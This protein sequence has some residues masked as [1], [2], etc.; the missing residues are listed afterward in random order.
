M[1]YSIGITGLGLLEVYIP[2]GAEVVYYPRAVVFG[3]CWD[4]GVGVLEVGVECGGGEL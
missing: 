3:R 4:K 2:R 1:F